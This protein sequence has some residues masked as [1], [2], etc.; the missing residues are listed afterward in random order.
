MMKTLIGVFMAAVL[1]APAVAGVEKVNFKLGGMTCPFCYGGLEKKLEKVEGVKEVK[2][3]RRNHLASCEMSQEGPTDFQALL[4][5]VED[6]G[7]SNEGIEVTASGKLVTEDGKTYL[8]VGKDER[9][10]LQGPI[11]EPD[12]EGVVR[13][14]GWLEFE[15]ETLILKTGEQK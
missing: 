15:K 12:K 8:E 5:A 6:S 3:S 4:K 10:L 1:A 7:F 2:V 14:T 9:F 11:A 13:V